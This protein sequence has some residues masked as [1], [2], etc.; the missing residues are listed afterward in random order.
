MAENLDFLPD[1]IALHNEFDLTPAQSDFYEPVAWYYNFDETTAKERNYG[2]LYNSEAADYLE[3]HKSTLFPGWHV[4]TRAELATLAAT[5]TR[6]SL[7]QSVSWAG[8]D[9]HNEYC[10]NTTGFSAIPNGNVERQWRSTLPYFYRNGTGMGFWTI[11]DV[12]Y[13]TGIDAQRYYGN[14]T[15]YSYF[16]GD[17]DTYKVGYGLA[18]RLVKD[19]STLPNKVRISSDAA[20]EKS[21][22]GTYIAG[23]QGEGIE[24]E[25]GLLS[26]GENSVELYDTFKGVKFGAERAVADRDGNIIDETYAKKSEVPDVS[27]FQQK[28]VPDTKTAAATVTVENNKVTLI[29]L[30]SGHSISA[31][32]ISCAVAAG[33]SANFA[34]EIDNKSASL[35]CV[36]TLVLTVGGVQQ[37]IRLAA[38]SG[39]VAKVKAGKYY[40]LTCVGSCW[41]LAEFA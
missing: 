3:A 2:L 4:P 10:T 19:D 1:G 21:I 26:L 38:A 8:G 25:S 30:A 40:Q 41:T 31:M 13:S 16:T 24:G 17:S 14:L 35:D 36:V 39:A 7:R 33:E 34:V 18:I 15:G 20:L 23:E 12:M 6:D 9:W 22:Y 5:A 37:T 27:Q 29:E 11:T 32:E 28:L